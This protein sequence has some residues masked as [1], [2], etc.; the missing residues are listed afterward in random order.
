MAVYTFTAI[1]CRFASCELI[2][3]GKQ[4]VARE[5]APTDAAGLIGITPVVL[6]P[7]AKAYAYSYR[8]TLSELYV[9]DGLK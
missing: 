8:R 7:D 2:P 1:S 9:V 3:T 4:T 6:S 5:L